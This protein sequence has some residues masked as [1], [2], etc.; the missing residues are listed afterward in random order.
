MKDY[1][2]IPIEGTAVKTYLFRAELVE[3][4]DGRWSVGV[5]TLPG[6]VTWG[7]TKAEAFHNIHAVTHAYLRDMKRL[8]TQI[9][10]SPAAQVLDDLVVTVTVENQAVL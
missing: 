4:A 8:G 7:Y 5:P 10:T 9:P 6:C 1:Q 3:E 2:Y